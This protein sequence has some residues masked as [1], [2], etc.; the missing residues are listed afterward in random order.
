MSTLKWHWKKSISLQILR[1]SS[2][3]WQITLLWILRSYF[4]NFG[5]K[6]PIK[7]P[8]LRLSSALVKICQKRSWTFS[9]RVMYVQ[10]TPCVCRVVCWAL[11]ISANKILA[12]DCSKIALVFTEP[13]FHSILVPSRTR[14]QSNLS[15]SFPFFFFLPHWFVNLVLKRS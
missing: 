12:L 1:H 6:D 7:I 9:E 10:F 2:L 3:S 5:W 4:F 13:W 8:I 15:A 11:C 14:L